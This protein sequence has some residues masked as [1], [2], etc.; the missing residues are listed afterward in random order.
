MSTTMNDRITC[1][2][3]L[4]SGVQKGNDGIVITCPVCG[5]SGWKYREPGVHVTY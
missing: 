3:C 5:G 4:G 2:G 1:P